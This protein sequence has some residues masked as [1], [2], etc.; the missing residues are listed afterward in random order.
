MVLIQGKC[1]CMSFSSNPDKSDLI[2]EYSTKISLVEEYLVLGL[3]IG[4][5]MTFYS[6]TTLKTFV[7]K[8]KLNDF[9][10][11]GKPLQCF[12]VTPRYSLY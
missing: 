4:N 5:R 1:G 3:T 6:Q 2:L 12:H 10:V 9:R 7:K 11:T 8:M